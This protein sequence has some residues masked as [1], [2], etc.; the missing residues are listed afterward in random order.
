VFRQGKRQ[1]DRHFEA[2]G[3][4]EVPGHESSTRYHFALFGGSVSDRRRRWFSR[5]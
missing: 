4:T 5:R 2:L 3:A 1:P